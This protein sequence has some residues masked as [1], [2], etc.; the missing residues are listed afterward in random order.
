MAVQ[1]LCTYDDVYALVGDL[2]AD[3]WTSAQLQAFCDG[4][5]TTLGFIEQNSRYFEKQSGQAFYARTETHYL[6]GRGTNMVLLPEEVL[7]PITNL[8][9]SYQE[10]GTG[11]T[12]TTHYTW[13]DAGIIRL[14][15][16]SDRGFYSRSEMPRFSVGTNNVQ[17][18]V[19]YGSDVV[20]ADVRGA[21]AQ[22][23]AIDLT[24]R[25][26]REA[27]R[28]IKLR[29]LGDRREDYGIG[30]QFSE[31]ILLWQQFVN[32]TIAVYRGGV[33]STQASKSG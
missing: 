6:S 1:D 22:L 33:G 8:V 24:R 5:A 28:G 7:P 14:T 18:T 3:K 4:N 32:D 17:A 26:V 2:L 20:P 29:V 12:E 13:N 16:A 27:G 15:G 10:I 30:G 11:W 25:Y 21:V 9:L 19:T 23:C 31:D